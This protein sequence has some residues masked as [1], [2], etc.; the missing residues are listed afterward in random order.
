MTIR[1]RK[2]MIYLSEDEKTRIL[3]AAG[4]THNTPKG[5]NLGRFIREAALIQANTV[6]ADT[7]P[8][9]VQIYDALATAY[10]DLD[11][12]VTRHPWLWDVLCAAFACNNSQ[13]RHHVFKW[14]AA[15]EIG[16][17]QRLISLSSSV[18]DPLCAAFDDNG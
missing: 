17:P 2:L 4:K 7:D 3:Q 16:D 18:L 6:I 14:I 15:E 1:E 11:Q 9:Q 8:R 13:W 12:L 10:P 5:Q